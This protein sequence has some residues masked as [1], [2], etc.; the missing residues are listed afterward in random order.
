MFKIDNDRVLPILAWIL[1]A[2]DKEL[3]HIKE[4]T[5]L[6]V[7]DGASNEFHDEGLYSTKI[8]G[9]VGSEE[10]DTNYGKIDLK[11]RILHPAF[12]E[13]LIAIKALY[14]G[15][16]DGTEYVEFDET[17]KDFVR[18]KSP[19]ARTGYSFFISR[20]ND[21]VFKTNS[22]KAR[23]ERIKFIVERRDRATMK[24]LIVIPAGVR[25]IDRDADE[26]LVKHEI[27]DFY[28]R[29]LSMARS[30][31]VSKDMESEVYDQIRKV[32]TIAVYDLYKYLESFIG[33]NGF[34]ESKFTSRRIHDGTRNVLTSMN[35]TGKFL[36][37]SDVPGYDSTV[38]GIYQVATGLSPLV[39]GW[40]R[41]GYLS[42]IAEVESGDVSL[43]NM[44]TLK[45]EYVELNPR[46]RD[47][48]TTEDGLRSV[49]H[50][51]SNVQMRH[52][53]IVIGKHYLSL[54]YQ[55]DKTFKIF[56]D[57]DELPKH[58]SKSNVR[59]LS[60][61]ELIYLSGYSRFSKHFAT[62]TRYPL[63]NED[64]IYPS[65][66]HCKTTSTGLVLRELGVD[67]LPIEGDDFLAVEFPDNKSSV[68]HDSLS[69]H[70][71]RLQNLGA[72]RTRFID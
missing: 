21:I 13:R 53:P 45:R 44:K 31:I 17:E 25:D 12:Y 43:V 29:V 33:G 60:L 24:N 19:N 42:K 66:I 38:A 47:K 28:T 69:P 14:K 2:E 9:R 62:V 40:M 70:G 65:R 15:I 23:S 72:D 34:I 59:P 63:N 16:L 3:A 8:F 4:V 30:I 49:I 26:R 41:R 50:D 55:D 20:F 57:I 36:G 6:D 64:S 61:I 11:V 32:M 48:W 1:H 54:I 56:D 46:L 35:T 22:S 71:S 18:S 7:T 5:R 37:S 27:N 51:L 10:R 58:L 67:W 39:I 68:F 52:S